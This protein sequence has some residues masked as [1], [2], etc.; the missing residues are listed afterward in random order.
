MAQFV[1]N[2]Q[3]QFQQFHAAERLK[4]AELAASHTLQLAFSYGLAEMAKLGYSQLEL[5]GA[6]QFIYLVLN[7]SEELKPAGA[8]QYPS[9]P[10]LDENA[11]QEPQQAS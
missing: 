7:L 11:P 6:N 1:L 9:Q 2:P 3:E 5:R 10:L 8:T 4:W